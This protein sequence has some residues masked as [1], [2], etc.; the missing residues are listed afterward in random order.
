MDH[1]VFDILEELGFMSV[2]ITGIT[3]REGDSTR[4]GQEGGS[5]GK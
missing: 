2:K 1:A 3:G 5:Q 4:D